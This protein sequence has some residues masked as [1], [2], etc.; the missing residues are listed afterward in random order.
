MKLFSAGLKK[1]AS[2]SGSDTAKNLIS[3]FDWLGTNNKKELQ[4]HFASLVSA[5]RYPAAL[6]F[7]LEKSPELYNK[8]LDL[9][10]DL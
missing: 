6:N 1:S 9:T 2:T 7:I 5:E 10:N 4:A 8:L 3:Y